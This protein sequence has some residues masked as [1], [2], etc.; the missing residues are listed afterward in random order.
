MMQGLSSRT[1]ERAG[2]SSLIAAAAGRL[3]IVASVILAAAVPA[4]GADPIKIG[5][6]LTYIGP[7]AIFARYEAKGAELAIEEIN[8][9]GGINGSLIELVKYDTEGKPDRAGTLFRRLAEED[10][11]AAVIGPDSIFVVLGMSGVPAQV[12]MMS[13]AA[14]GGFE[15]VNPADRPWIVSAW[16]SPGI[17][18]MMVLSYLKDKLRVGR[19]G[20]LTSADTIGDHTGREIAASAKL[21][22]I[23]PVETVAQ[24]STDR[25]L[26][27]SLRKLAAIKPALD[28]IFIYGSGPFGTIAVNQT[29]L[30]G[31]NVPIG[32]VGGNIIPEIIKDIA[33][34]TGK[35]LYTSIP[36]A[37]VVTTLPKDDPYYAKIRKFADDYA[38]KYKEPINIPTAVGYDMAATIIDALKAVGPD[39]EKLRDYIYNRQKNFVGVQGLTFNRTP[40]DGYGTDM[41]DTVVVNAEN[42]VWTFKGY[43]KES[44]KNLK[45]SDEALHGLQREFKL[46]TP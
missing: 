15:L 20:I 34:E 35:R 33:P 28:A 16:G 10:K 4:R 23:E 32:Y 46:L 30:A 8:K 45:I 31:I 22:G 19:I 17:A 21:A 12:K 41:A 43:T 36:R 1:G 13:V 44:M 26:L 3:A 24:P 25:D 27:P 29:E 42:G 7:T 18:G 6:L 40:G 5:L 14:P 11:V 37:G 2:V 9:A 38:A 39:R